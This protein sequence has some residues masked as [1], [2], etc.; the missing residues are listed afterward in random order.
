MKLINFG[1]DII[2]T[3]LIYDCIMTLMNVDQTVDET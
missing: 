3:G 2:P 1:D